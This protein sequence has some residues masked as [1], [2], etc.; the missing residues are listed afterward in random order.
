MPWLGLLGF[1]VGGSPA[2][3]VPPAPPAPPAPPVPPAPPA[4]PRATLSA[5]TTEASVAE[6][7]ASMKIPP[8]WPR[9]LASVPAP[10]G[11]V[12]GVP[13]W[14]EPPSPAGVPGW[15]Y[16][17]VVPAVPAAPAGAFAPALPGAP[18][19]VPCRTATPVSV[20]APPLRTSNTREV[21]PPSKLLSASPPLSDTVLPLTTNEAAGPGTAI[22]CAPLQLKT[23]EPP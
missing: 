19:A 16:V 11:V 9:P 5:R 10:P 12:A 4:P 7:V 18:A 22:V 20:S 23:Y 2:P 3:P 15:E 14:P 13:G 8:P 1:G 6:L 21:P 17:P